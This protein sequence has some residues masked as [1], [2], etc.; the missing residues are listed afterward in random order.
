MA[1][2]DLSDFERQIKRIYKVLNF[3]EVIG[4]VEKAEQTKRYLAQ[5]KANVVRLV[6][7]YCLP[8]FAK[9]GVIGREKATLAQES[10][11]PP[12]AGSSNKQV[13]T[14]IALPPFGRGSG[15]AMLAG[16]DDIIR[17]GGLC[18]SCKAVLGGKEAG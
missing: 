1:L 17:Y 15:Q 18:S 5:S 4:M 11:R 16:Y 7:S 2:G 6:L 14:N 10:I 9:P 8:S 3:E 13:V 12:R